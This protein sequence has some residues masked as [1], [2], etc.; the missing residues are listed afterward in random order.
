MVEPV[1]GEGYEPASLRDRA[2]PSTHCIHLSKNINV[3]RTS[4]EKLHSSRTRQARL[5]EARHPER[6]NQKGESLILRYTTHYILTRRP[7]D[8]YRFNSSVLHLRTCLVMRHCRC[9]PHRPGVDRRQN[10]ATNAAPAPASSITPGTGVRAPNSYRPSSVR[11]IMGST[12][13]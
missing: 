4:V 6:A 8:L 10:S 9:S 2:N 12:R 13:V 3:L 11:T 1:R 5:L 7:P